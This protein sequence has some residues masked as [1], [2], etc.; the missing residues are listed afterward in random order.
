MHRVT[1]CFI[2][3]AAAMLLSTAL[4]KLYSAT[5][6]AKILDITDALLPMS[7]RQ[8]LCLLGVVELAIVAV[9]LSRKSEITKLIYVAWLAG[10]FA[11]YRVGSLFLAVGKPCPCLGSV[12]E[13]LHLNQF[14]VER[15]LSISVVYLLF[16]SIFLLVV[17]KRPGCGES[18]C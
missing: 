3:S 6:N 4:A 14:I 5:G 18:V 2:K 10:N 12:T 16:G 7:I 9:L 17:L 8:L 15:F 11:L 13:K 1:Q